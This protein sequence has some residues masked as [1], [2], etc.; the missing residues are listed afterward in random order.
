MAII[1]LNNSGVDHLYPDGVEVFETTLD[2]VDV[3]KKVSRRAGMIAQVDPFFANYSDEQKN[4]VSINGQSDRITDDMILD[5]V[6]DIFPLF[7]YT[8]KFLP[9]RMDSYH[10]FHQGINFLPE[11][12]RIFPA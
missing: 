3:K 9:G 10:Q 8:V 4:L 6:R 12:L 2:I 5:A 11:P 7:R 1:E